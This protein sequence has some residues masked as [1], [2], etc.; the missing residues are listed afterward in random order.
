[1]NIKL[2][3]HADLSVHKFMVV[4]RL[5]VHKNEPLI[6]YQFYLAEYGSF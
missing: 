3:L 4:P 6:I 2:E 1:M 5:S